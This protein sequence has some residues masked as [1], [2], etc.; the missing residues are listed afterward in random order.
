[1]FVTFQDTLV[2][3]L[4]RF[5]LSLFCGWFYFFYKLCVVLCVFCFWFISGD[6]DPSGQTRV[7]S[8]DWNNS[9]NCLTNLSMWE[10]RVVRK[11]CIVVP[12]SQTWDA[13]PAFLPP[14]WNKK[15]EEGMNEGGREQL[16]SSVPSWPAPLLGEAVIRAGYLLPREV[17]PRLTNTLQK[18]WGCSRSCLPSHPHLGPCSSFGQ[19]FNL[20]EPSLQNNYKT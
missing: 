19:M 17:V 5:L 15:G 4:S 14:Q 7:H 11:G 12:G 6:R 16:L 2:W 20:H 18:L 3:S 13:W 1:M 9:I 8:R 10:D